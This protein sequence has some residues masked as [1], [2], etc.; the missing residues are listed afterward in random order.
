MDGLSGTFPPAKVRHFHWKPPLFSAGRQAARSPTTDPHGRPARNPVVSLC[1]FGFHWLEFF[2]GSHLRLRPVT[3]RGGLVLIDRFYY[4]FFVDQRRYRLRVPQS[5]V[6]LGHFFLKKPDLVVLLDAP[7]DV[8]QSRKQEVPLAETERQRAAYREL[9]QGLSNGRVIDAT[10]PPE[11][12]GADINRAILDFMA[13]RTKQALGRCDTNN[14]RH[15]RISG[16]PCSPRLRSR[17]RVSG[18]RCGC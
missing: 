1:Y 11:K 18:S 17:G 5:I 13:E 10:Q 16:K 3:F 14:A 4:D 15:R 9:V 8:L 12:V 7:A 6:R 2:L